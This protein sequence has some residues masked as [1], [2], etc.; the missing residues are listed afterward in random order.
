MGS[1]CNWL[2]DHFCVCAESF[3]SRDNAQLQQGAQELEHLITGLI[4]SIESEKGS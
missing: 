2:N 3:S 4:N 1:Y